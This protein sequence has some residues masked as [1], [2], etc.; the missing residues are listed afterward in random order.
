LKHL[1]ILDISSGTLW[2]DS[3]SQISLIQSLQQLRLNGVGNCDL[4][5]LVLLKNLRLL[6]LKVFTNDI[7]L[8]ELR[9]QLPDLATIVSR[10]PNGCIHQPSENELIAIN[11]TTRSE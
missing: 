6:D 2:Q 9:K 7:S 10:P 4:A 5:P 8:H 1:A 11:G 3:L